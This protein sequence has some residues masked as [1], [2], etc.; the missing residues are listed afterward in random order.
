MGYEGSRKSAAICPA[1]QPIQA[2][3]CT[4]ARISTSGSPA[5]G[6]AHSVMGSSG[7]TSREAGWTLG[8]KRSA[9]FSILISLALRL[10]SL[11]DDLDIAACQVLHVLRSLLA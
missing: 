2:Y 6:D 1:S 8:T 4:T 7:I 11:A 9:L 3:S 10:S 5:T